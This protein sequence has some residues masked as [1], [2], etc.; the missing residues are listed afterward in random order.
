MKNS[1]IIVT[2]ILGII[3]VPF[4]QIWALNTLFGLTIPYGWETWLAMFMIHWFFYSS[5]AAARLK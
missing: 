4:A 2:L 5:N 1:A 3:F